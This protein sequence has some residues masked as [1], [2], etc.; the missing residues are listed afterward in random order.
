MLI[1][2]LF[3]TYYFALAGLLTLMEIANLHDNRLTGSIPSEFGNWEKLWAL[4]LNFN[5]ATGITP[6]EWG[7]AVQL[8]FDNAWDGNRFTGTIPSAL[9][10]CTNLHYFWAPNGDL[11]GK[12][13]TELG[14]LSG[15]SHVSLANNSQLEGRFPVEMI[16][17]QQVGSLV[18]V[19][20]TGTAIVNGT[21]TL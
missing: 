20:V 21:T 10:N 1:L 13:P 9:G 18:H 14:L 17:L 16:A 2:S 19:D 12:I 5:Q 15:L 7:G 3:S 4:F 8:R 6:V 11:T